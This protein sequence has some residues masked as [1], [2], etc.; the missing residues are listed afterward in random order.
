MASLCEQKQQSPG[1]QKVRCAR[2]VEFKSGHAEFFSRIETMN[3]R[4]THP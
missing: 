3:S 1:V 2:R 4:R